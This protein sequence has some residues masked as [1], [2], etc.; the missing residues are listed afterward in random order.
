MKFV[1]K[2]HID[3]RKWDETISN[4]KTEN[5]FC[6]S[7]YLDATSKNWG[8]LITEDYSSI[9]PVPYSSKLGV[10]QI[11]QPPFTRELTIFGDDFSWTEALSFL[12]KDFKAIQFRNGYENINSH[13]DARVHQLLHLKSDFKLSTNA[14][15]LIK[16]AAAIYTV[17]QA[18]NPTELIDLFKAT[19]FSKIDSI[20]E[21]DLITLS[22]LMNAAAISNQCEILQI[23]EDGKTMAAGCFLKDKKRIT[24]L[25]G[26]ATD[27][28]KKNGAMYALINHALEKYKPDFDVFDFGG[29]D[30]ENVA[31]FYKKFGATDRTYYNYTI[32]NLPGWFKALKKIKK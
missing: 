13:S 31:N 12:S 15:R 10:K 7:W 4:S 30:I 3:F 24:Y 9:L 6:Y 25:K 32:N 14:K 23:S 27:E 1:E 21:Q 18:D 16:K 26:A 2:E 11:Y 8:G 17:S 29:S 28:A 5:I 19:A 22:N 20:S